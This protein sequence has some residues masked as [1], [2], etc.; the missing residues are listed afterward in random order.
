[1]LNLLNNWFLT[2]VDDNFNEL[3]KNSFFSNDPV[4]NKID[5]T[6]DYLFEVIPIILASFLIFLYLQYRRKFK[7]SLFFIIV[8]LINAFFIWG[9]KI[10][11]QRPRPVG[12]AFEALASGYGFPS[13]HTTN[14]IVFLGLLAYF[15]WK[16]LKNNR[17]NVKILVTTFCLIL[18]ILV[19]FSRLYLGIHWLTDVLGGLFLGLFILFLGIFTNEKFF[20]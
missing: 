3:M 14:V 11:I 15:S 8:M 4:L 19:S 6:L 1:M 13:G 16:Y 7:D 20:N 17:R 2:S 12:T 18:I 10:I 5:L 9:L